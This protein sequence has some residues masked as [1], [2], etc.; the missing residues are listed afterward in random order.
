LFHNFLKREKAISCFKDKILKKRKKKS[1]NLGRLKRRSITV[2]YV[3]A[4]LMRMSMRFLMACV[5]SAGMTK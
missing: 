5:G 1:A 2:L 3:A 4:R